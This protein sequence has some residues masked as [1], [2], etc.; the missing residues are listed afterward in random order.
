MTIQPETCL[1]HNMQPEPLDQA[2]QAIRSRV[3]A[4][5]DKPNATVKQQLEVVDAL[6]RFGLGRFLLIHRGINGYWTRYLAGSDPRYGIAAGVNDEGKPLSELE[7]WM[8]GES[9]GAYII[10][11]RQ[12]AAQAILR[13]NMRD[14]MVLA[15]VPCGAM[16][17]LLGLDFSSHRDVRLV[18]IDVD[19]A[20]L[21][22]AE[23]N[24]RDRSMIDRVELIE[25][26]AWNMGI[27]DRFDVLMSH[28]LSGYEPDRRR[29]V[30]LYKEFRKAIKPEGTFLAYFTTPPPTADAN[31]SWDRTRITAESLRRHELIFKHVLQPKWWPGHSTEQEVTSRLR[32]AGFSRIE[33]HPDQAG[34][35]TTVMAWK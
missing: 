8:L 30:E 24:A 28:G 29:L 15:S 9:P 12:R 14:G 7:R 1:S 32:A 13:Q 6:L 10:Q 5:G 11:E 19:P 20:S 22:L 27:T 34:I 25:A 18:G 31:S 21:R 4:E 23:Q 33:P 3:R 26:D 35:C 17:D 16:D 2:V